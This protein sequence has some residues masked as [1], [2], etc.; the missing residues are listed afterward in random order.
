MDGTHPNSKKIWLSGGFDCINMFLNTCPILKIKSKSKNRSLTANYK[1]KGLCLR[2]IISVAEQ[3]F[4]GTV[5]DH[6]FLTFSEAKPQTFLNRT[7]GFSAWAT[8]TFPGLF[9]PW[10]EGGLRWRRRNLTNVQEPFIKNP[11]SHNFCKW[12]CDKIKNN[13]LKTLVINKK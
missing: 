1:D 13:Y 8:D 7:R 10:A 11:K 3:D 5:L 2:L 12:R 9:Q 6:N 4:C